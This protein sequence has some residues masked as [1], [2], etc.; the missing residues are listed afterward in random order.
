[1]E[2]RGHQPVQF[3][4]SEVFLHPFGALRFVPGERIGRDDTLRHRFAD[5]RVQPCGQQDDSSRRDA[6][7]RPQVKVVPVDE[8]PVEGGKGNIRE[9]ILCL[10]ESGDAITGIAIGSERVFLAVYTHALLE[11]FDKRLKITKQGCLSGSLAQ[12][13]I[14]YLFGGHDLPYRRLFLVDGQRRGTQFVQL[15]IDFPSSGTLS[16]GA[17]RYPRRYGNR[18][19]G[20]ESRLGM[21]GPTVSRAMTGQQ[22]LAFVSLFLR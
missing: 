22:P 2:R 8:R 15:P 21:V 7:F 18:H 16:R 4:G 5:D 3:V 11:M 17:A 12:Q 6:A 13:Q 9:F 20:T 10:Q 19:L 14:P 1:M